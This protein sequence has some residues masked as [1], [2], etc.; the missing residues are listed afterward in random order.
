MTYEGTSQERGA[1]RITGSEWIERYQ[2]AL[3][4]T[5][6]P[7]QLVLVRGEGAYVWDV[8][9]NRYLDLLGGIA[10]NALGHAHPAILD[11]VNTQL[12]TL[13]HVSNFFTSTPQVELAE[14]LLHLIGPSGPAGVPGR[15]RQKA[16]CFSPAQAPRRTRRLSRRPVAPGAPPSSPRRAASTDARWARSR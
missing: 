15:G 16:G 3:M 13:G 2:G 4:N 5:F 14:K 8:D 9:G 6:G 12:S 7:P 11:A 10:V 1:N